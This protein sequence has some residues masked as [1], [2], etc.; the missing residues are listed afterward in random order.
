MTIYGQFVEK[1]E[2]FYRLMQENY[3]KMQDSWLGRVKR[4]DGSEY[5]D[6]KWVKQF[7]FHDSNCLDLLPDS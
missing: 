7:L 1:L 3:Q 5:S 6:A 4:E 2:N